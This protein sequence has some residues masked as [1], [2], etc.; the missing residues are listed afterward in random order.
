MLTKDRSVFRDL[1]EEESLSGDKN[2]QKLKFKGCIIEPKKDVNIIKEQYS[3]FHSKFVKI[4]DP[5]Y[6]ADEYERMRIRSEDS[7]I[8]NP[9]NNNRQ[10]QSY[11]FQDNQVVNEPTPKYTTKVGTGDIYGYGIQTSEI[12][13]I[14]NETGGSW[15]MTDGGHR[16]PFSTDIS[17]RANEEIVDAVSFPPAIKQTK[18]SLLR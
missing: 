6:L 11:A 14:L 15:S 7:S 10:S 3:T 13:R 8:G 9:I 1:T 12:T 5:P 4:E 17:I 2:K 18:A 16:D